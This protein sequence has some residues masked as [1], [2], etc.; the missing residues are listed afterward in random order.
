[1][2]RRFCCEIKYTILLLIR[3]DPEFLELFIIVDDTKFE[4]GQDY[5]H[6]EIISIFLIVSSQ[7]IVVF[8]FSTAYVN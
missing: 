4:H 7:Y 3:D 8:T 5:D 6:C 1:M 2:L